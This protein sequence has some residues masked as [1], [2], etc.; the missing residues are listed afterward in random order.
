MMQMGGEIMGTLEEI[1]AHQDETFEEYIAR[2][3]IENEKP[4]RKIYLR[5][6]M[7]VMK[8]YESDKLQEAFKTVLLGCSY[9]HSRSIFATKSMYIGYN[10]ETI[11]ISDHSKPAYFGPC[12]IF[13]KK[14]TWG[15]IKEYLKQFKETR[16]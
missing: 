10:D 13:N 1:L 11:R 5:D 4:E 15:E 2:K 14:T 9:E 16:R 8:M 6:N 12:F 7:N 3:K